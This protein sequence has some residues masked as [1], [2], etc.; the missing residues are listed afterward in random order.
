M[1]DLYYEAPPRSGSN[2]EN[3]A[4]TVR[5]VFGLSAVRFFPV[6]DFVEKG[7]EQIVEGLTFDVVEPSEL[8]RRM[9]AVD[10]L[11]RSLYLREDVYLGAANRNNRDRFTVA[12]ESGHAIMHIGTLNRLQL[13]QD[14]PPY[15]DPEWQANRFAAALLMPRHLVRQCTT[16]GEIVRDFGV[17]RVSAE[18]RIKQLRMEI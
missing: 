3:L 9:G 10:P 4:D 14:V 7:L 5:K 18:L 13:S 12:H 17:S 2:I 8:G 6:V 1:N 11:R 16:I 15:R